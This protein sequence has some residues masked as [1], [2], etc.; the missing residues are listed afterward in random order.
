LDDEV[1]AGDHVD[2]SAPDS[3][4]MRP[5]LLGETEFVDAPPG[6]FGR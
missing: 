1:G 3:G 5:E 4:D 2:V 6:E